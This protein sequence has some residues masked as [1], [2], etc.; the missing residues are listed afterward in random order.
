M[1]S[2]L[3]YHPPLPPADSGTG[4]SL[5]RGLVVRLKNRGTYILRQIER[6]AADGRLEIKAR[7]TAVAMIASALSHGYSCIGNR[8]TCSAC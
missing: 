6:L 5:L 1:C 8:S 4:L 3:A 2:S 7:A